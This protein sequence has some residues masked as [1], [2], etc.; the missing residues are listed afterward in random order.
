MLSEFKFEAVSPGICDPLRQG[1]W[2]RQRRA[3]LTLCVTYFPARTR[4]RKSTATATTIKLNILFNGVVVC[5]SQTR[6]G[7]GVESCILCGR[8]RP[9]EILEV[10]WKRK[11]Y[12]ECQTSSV[13]LGNPCIV[14]AKQQRCFYS[15]PSIDTGFSSVSLKFWRD[16]LRKYI[17]NSAYLIK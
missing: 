5:V 15:H 10:L 11:L 7:V 16:V 8:Q 12:C 9:L 13:N 3:G 1:L 14:L 6:V 17:K 4:R 2:Q